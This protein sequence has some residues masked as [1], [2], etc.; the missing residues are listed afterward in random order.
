MKTNGDSVN[1][2]HREFIQDVTGQIA[3]NALSFPVNPGR[4]TLFTWLPQLATRYERYQFR[5]L[6]FIYEPRCSTATSGSVI[7]A[8]DYDPLDTAPATKQDVYSYH[9][10][11]QSSPWDES[12]LTVDSSILRN[13]GTLFSRAGAIPAGSDLKTYDL[14]NLWLCVSGFTGAVV[15]GELFVE[16]DVIL[17]VPQITSNVQSATLVP[18]GIDVTHQVGS[19]STFVPGSTEGNGLSPLKFLSEEPHPTKRRKR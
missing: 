15:C 9:H 17:M 8:M 3:F 2:H 14:G 16:Y 1:I 7:L 18:G 19:T 10:S 5:N 13:R 12:C 11:A 4:D 6:R